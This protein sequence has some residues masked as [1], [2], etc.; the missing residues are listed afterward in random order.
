MF[1]RAQEWEFAVILLRAIFSLDNIVLPLFFSN[2]F[3][4]LSNFDIKFGGFNTHLSTRTDLI[5]WTLITLGLILFS[6]NS[7]EKL[8]VFK[9]DNK[10]F[11]L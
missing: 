8:K 5:F 9:T 3:Y 10:H 1:F 2:N 4:F 7:M 6:K 11:F